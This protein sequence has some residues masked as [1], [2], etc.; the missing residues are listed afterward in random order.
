MSITFGGE[1]DAPK[2]KTN[3]R[4]DNVT[5]TNADVVY[6]KQQKW[7]QKP[8]DVGIEM[9][10]D[11]GKD[12][13]PTFYLGGIFKAEDGVVTGWSSAY[14]IKILLEAVVLTGARLDKDAG[15]EAQRFPSDLADQLKG[16]KFARLSYKSIKA[17]PD[18]NG[19][20]W[21]DWQTV[22][23]ENHFEELRTSFKEAIEH[24]DP[25]SNEPAP[26][27]KNFLSPEM[28]GDTELDGPWNDTAE[29]TAT[30]SNTAVAEAPKMP[31]F[32]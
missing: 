23:P 13:F 21:S 27:V 14:K 17:K 18:G 9:T 32:N 19:H 30:N 20:Y 31:S 8:D 26:Y 5:I 10:L 4:I 7:Q 28:E 2:E 3:I 1:N 11:I 16:R 25:Q 22:A 15:P 29:D 12:W 24:R 6:N